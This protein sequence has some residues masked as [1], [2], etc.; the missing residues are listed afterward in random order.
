MTAVVAQLILAFASLIVAA[1]VVGYAWCCGVFAVA[2]RRAKHLA[3]LRATESRPELPPTRS[4]RALPGK[5]APPL[6]ARR[7]IKGEVER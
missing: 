5:P 7:V 2:P 3:A 1:I 6:S 4:P